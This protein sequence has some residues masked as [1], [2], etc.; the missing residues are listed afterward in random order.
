MCPHQPVLRAA[1]AFMKQAMYY[2]RWATPKKAHNH[3]FV[4]LL[5]QLLRRQMSIM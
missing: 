1:Q 5:G 3:R 4:S 2:L